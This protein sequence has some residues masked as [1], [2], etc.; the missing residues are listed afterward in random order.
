MNLPLQM[1]SIVRK[2]SAWSKSRI[3]VESGFVRPA[4]RGVPVSCT[5]AGCSCTCPDNE[6]CYTCDN[7]TTCSCCSTGDAEKCV[8]TGC[9]CYNP[10]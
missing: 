2:H 5:T 9:Q 7:C 10:L 4:A 1:A 3:A 8:G 6:N